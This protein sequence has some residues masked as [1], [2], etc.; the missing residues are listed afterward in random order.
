[1]QVAGE[2]GAL[3][4]PYRIDRPLPGR[5]DGAQVDG[6]ADDR[7][8]GQAESQAGDDVVGRQAAAQRHEA[9]RH[10]DRQHGGDRPLRVAPA[11]DHV[12]D[13]E[14]ADRLGQPEAATDAA[15][16]HGERDRQQQRAPGEQHRDLRQTLRTLP[17]PGQPDQRG[18]HRAD[19]HHRR[20][21]QAAAAG[22]GAQV[23]QA[24][25]GH[26]DQGGDLAGVEQK[27]LSRQHRDP[28]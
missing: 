11:G 12:H 20:E 19:D 28:A 1:M 17:V 27:I 9:D 18:R 16:D 6:Q 24:E 22:Q 8:R 4:G 25:N 2:L 23:D 7:G 26:Q 3:L 5:L 21:Q 10:A 14:Q 13:A 15:G